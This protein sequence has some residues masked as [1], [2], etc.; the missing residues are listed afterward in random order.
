MGMHVIRPHKLKSYHHYQ[1]LQKKIH[2]HCDILVMEVKVTNIH[3]YWIFQWGSIIKSVCSI[4]FEL[5]PHPEHLS[6]SPFELPTLLEWLSSSPFLLDS[7]WSIVS[8]LCN[9]FRLF[10]FFSFGHFIVFSALFV[11]FA[12]LNL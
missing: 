3:K 12:L 8:L 2:N 11:G 10:V 1:I 7:C 6:S 4:A 9:V 5:P